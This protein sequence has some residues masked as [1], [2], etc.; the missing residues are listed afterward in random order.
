MFSCPNLDSVIS[1]VIQDNAVLYI[2]G[3]SFGQLK[4]FFRYRL[5]LFLFYSG[6]VMLECSACDCIEGKK[7]K[8]SPHLEADTSSGPEP[9]VLFC[10]K[11][12]RAVV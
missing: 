3:V 12:G 7:F 11:G 4:S 10:A 1:A 5:S 9:L 8:E 2:F 6:I